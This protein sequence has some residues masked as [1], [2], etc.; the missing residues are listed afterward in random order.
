MTQRRVRMCNPAFERL[1]GYRLS[2][3]AGREPQSFLTPADRV[4]ESDGIVASAHDGETV[5]TKTKRKRRDGQ[6]VDVQF[7][8]M[9]LILD[10]KIIGSVGIYED[11]GERAAA[12]RAQ[13]SAE[14]RFQR[15][16]ENAIEGIFQST[17]GRPVT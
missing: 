3:I 1:F 4:H 16:F 14:E 6:L 12:E 2:E 17:V 7:L 15:I 9:P 13:R 11:I 5:R 10:G 8:A